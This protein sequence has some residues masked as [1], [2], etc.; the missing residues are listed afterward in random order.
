[1]EINPDVYE[2]EAIIFCA[3]DPM[4]PNK[5][6]YARYISTNKDREYIHCNGCDDMDGS[7][8]CKRCCQGTIDVLNNHPSQSLSKPFIP[9][10]T[11]EEHW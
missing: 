7:T 5:K 8:F 11:E 6:V 1:M 3:R 10:L 4:Y 9:T 2:T